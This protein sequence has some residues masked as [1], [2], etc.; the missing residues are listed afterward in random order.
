MNTSPLTM[1][2]AL[3]TAACMLLLIFS[4]IAFYQPIDIEDIGWHIKVGEWIL[5]Q[6]QFPEVDPFYFQPEAQVEWISTQWLGSISFSWIYHTAGALG[7]KL[8]RVAI[9][10]IAL[11]IAFV[12]GRR[13]LP[14]PLLFT[15]LFALGLGM[16][17]RCQLRPFLYNYIFLQIFFLMLFS[18]WN[19]GDRRSLFLLPILGVIWY[20]THLGAFVYGSIVLFIFTFAAAVQF[21]NAKLEKAK[22]AQ[23]T[24][25]GNRCRDLLLTSLAFMG[26]FILNPYGLKGMLYPYQVFLFKKFFDIYQVRN[27]IVELQPPVY[28]A[29][30]SW[31]MRWLFWSLWFYILALVAIWLLCKNKSSQLLLF[32]LLAVPL[33]LYFYGVR[34]QDFL[35][36]SVCYLIFECSKNLSLKENWPHRLNGIF[37][38]CVLICATAMSLYLF[39][40]KVVVN[41]RVGLLSNSS[42]MPKKPEKALQYLKSREF[43]GPVLTNDSW[44]GT[45][46]LWGYPQIKPILDGRWTNYE[47]FYLYLKT[48]ASPEKYFSQLQ[49]E[50]NFSVVILDASQPS[51]YKLLAYLKDHP[52]WHLAYLQDETVIF[53]NTV[54]TRLVEDA[55]ILK[56]Q[57][58]ATTLSQDETESIDWFTID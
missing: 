29:G 5:E 40:Q 23:L 37:Y 11:G 43:E 4:F 42:F 55:T 49:Q 31:D 51:S 18:Y 35:L 46:L 36:I 19:N 56:A 21:F 17:S 45:V 14:W 7:L 33:A 52:D 30:I 39:N 32:L 12:Y 9:L 8:F 54:Q 53:A 50:C 34:A 48:T 28:L 13:R 24:V 44:G 20:N 10:W 38:S 27:I 22:T 26:S 3:K 47:L 41:K 16:A 15:V 25:W 6:K 57:L 58:N 2:Q 1:D